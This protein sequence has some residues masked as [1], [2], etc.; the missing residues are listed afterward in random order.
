M[1]RY[2]LAMTLSFRVILTGLTLVGGGALAQQPAP[3]GASLAAAAAR[4]FPQPVRVGDLIGRTV[5]RPL[6]SRPVLGY[7]AQVIRSNGA[8]KIVVSYGGFFGIDA[9]PIAVPA[10]AMVLVG[11]DL[12][13]VDFTPKQLAS[14]PTYHGSGVVAIA[15]DDKIS[16][17]LARPSH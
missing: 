1:G 10:D 16:M 13:I 2:L 4:R 11:T 6:E 12:E 17:G 15:P 14:F 5:L 3:P 7:V 9:T 8:V